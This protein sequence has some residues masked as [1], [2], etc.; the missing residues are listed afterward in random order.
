MKIRI[1][2]SD[3][4]DCLLITGKDGER[5]LADGGMEVSYSAS[6]APALGALAKAKKKLDV[7]YVSHIDDDHIAGILQLMDDL[8]AWRIFD[9]KVKQGLSP[10]APAA[11]R[12]PEVL[13]LWHNGFRDTVDD[14]EGA[15]EDQLAANATILSGF[16]SRNPQLNR[17]VAAHQDL[18]E[19]VAQAVKLNKRIADGILGIPHNAPANGKLMMVGSK[20]TVIDI[21]GMTV[22]VLG[23]FKADLETLRGEWNDWFEKSQSTIGKIRKEAKSQEDDLASGASFVAPLKAEATALAQALAMGVDDDLDDALAKKLGKK[24]AVTTPNIAS[25]TLLV[26]EAGKTILLTGDAH[27]DE[28]LKGLAHHGLLDA[29]GGIHVNVLKVQHHGSEHNMT[30]AFAKAVTAD[31]YVFCGNGFSTNPE[32]VVIQR[33]YDARLGPAD[34][35][36][37]NGV[38]KGF[39]FWFNSTSKLAPSDRRA[40]MKLVEALM[41]KLEA[42]GNGKLKVRWPEDLEGSQDFTP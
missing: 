5:I 13:N 16:T 29:N 1:F 6:V 35:R 28:V 36:S 14:N 12:P 19:S 38:K 10:K 4:G 37:P 25:L 30:D 26:E 17:A 42:A 27:A 20:K 2:P 34:Q 40:H 24:S 22:R 8:V 21:G 9:H 39:T 31:H 11:A 41:D 3:K 15:I 7:V 33:L 32:P 18:A 23:P